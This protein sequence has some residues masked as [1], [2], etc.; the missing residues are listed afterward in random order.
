MTLYEKYGRMKYEQLKRQNI[1]IP[2]KIG[3]VYIINI[4][5]TFLVENTCR[6]SK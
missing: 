4:N 2:I 5:T 6:C 1:I 3:S